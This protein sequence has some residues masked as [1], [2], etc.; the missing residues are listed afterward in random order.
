MLVVVDQP[1]S[2]VLLPADVLLGGA[3]TLLIV[4]LR[5]LLRAAAAQH[6]EL[7]SVI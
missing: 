2:V 7:E 6:R 1:M 3:A 4:L 5:G